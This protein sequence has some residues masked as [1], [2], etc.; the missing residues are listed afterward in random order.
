MLPFPSSPVLSPFDYEHIVLEDYA[1]QPEV[2]PIGV[3]GDPVFIKAPECENGVYTSKDRLECRAEAVFSHL[4]HGV[5]VVK[6]VKGLRVVAGGEVFECERVIYDSRPGAFIAAC[7]DG[8]YT[9]VVVAD[10]SGLKVHRELYRRKPRSVIIGFSSYSIVLEDHRSILLYPGG[11]VV[12]GIPL[13]IIAYVGDYL[14]GLSGRW[15]VRVKTDGSYGPLVLLKDKYE[16][17]GASS[18]LPVFKAVD[19]LCRLEGGALV[20]LDFAKPPLIKVYACDIV[21]V[22]NE[23]GESIRPL[24]QAL[25]RATK[26]PGVK[27]LRNPARGP[28]L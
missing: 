17:V 26:G 22:D 27:V 19:R 10:Y 25:P 21:V 2:T 20:E 3:I 12:I 23:R 13:S 9:H 28:V 8:S 11:P 7:Y 14:Y 4:S 15:L 24:R 16:F 1:L 6:S 18:G 5:A